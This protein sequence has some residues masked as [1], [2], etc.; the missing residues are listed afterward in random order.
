MEDF[1]T[2]T[3]VST[4]EYAKFMFARLY[5]K[6]VFIVA[7]FL[8]IYL[9]STSFFDSS[10]VVNFNSYQPFE[11]VCGIF[12]LLAPTLIALLSIRQ[13]TSN[14]ALRNDITYSFSATGLT[15]QGSTFVNKFLWS[16][17]IKQKE[18]GKF[19]ILY[20]HNKFGHLIDKT[21]LTSEQIKFIKQSVEQK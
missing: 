20:S 16:H 3:R 1:T 11:L 12:L 5:R 15:I 4:K 13:F 9:V 17:F 2:T 14:S 18:L 8:G 6:P 10:G 7:S 19:L 21:L